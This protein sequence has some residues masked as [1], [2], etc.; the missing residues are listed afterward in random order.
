MYWYIS[1][2]LPLLLGWCSAQ[3]P[4]V[5]Y[6]CIRQKP[7][8]VFEVIVGSGG[9]PSTHTASTMAFVTH[10]AFIE[11]F[12]GPLF[13][14]S[15]VFATVMMYDAFNVRLACGRVTER[16]N[17]MADKLYA[18]D[19]PDKPEKLKVVKGH[20]FLEVAVGLVIGVVVGAIYSLVEMHFTG[21]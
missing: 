12:Q 2:F 20:T 14:L 5:I 16:V 7:E 4:K 11:G 6:T 15:V 21:A 9:M 10:V 18:D 13:A 17:Q 19:D 1:F 3:I 8:N